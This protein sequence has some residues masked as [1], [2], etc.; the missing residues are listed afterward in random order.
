MQ[1]VPTVPDDLPEL[2]SGEAAFWLAMRS[3][4]MAL[5][6]TYPSVRV[7]VPGCGSGGDVQAVVTL[8]AETGPLRRAHV[9]ATDAT[10]E[11]V[12]RTRTALGETLAPDLFGR[13]LFSV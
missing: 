5:L 13:V 2:V 7:W 10:S 12:E 6:A 11:A 9:Y 4:V 8:L 3:D 1:S